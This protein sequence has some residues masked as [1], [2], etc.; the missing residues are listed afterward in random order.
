MAS[1]AGL[2]LFF[3][4]RFVFL[5]FLR[6]IDSWRLGSIDFPASCSK[7]KVWLLGHVHVMILLYFM[8][9]Q[10]ALLETSECKSRTCCTI[11]ER[12]S[13]QRLIKDDD[14]QKASVHMFYLQCSWPSPFCF[15][16]FDEVISDA[17]AHYHCIYV[18]EWQKLCQSW[19][20]QIPMLIKTLF[21]RIVSKS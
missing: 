11:L 14:G 10:S 2:Y 15:N 7:S 18:A 16:R 8:I 1:C 21:Q 13:L 6:P 19:C 20:V 9:G 17:S 5:D 3:S 4:I 12:F